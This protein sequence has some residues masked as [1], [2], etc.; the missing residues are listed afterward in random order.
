MNINIS[1]L[2]IVEPDRGLASAPTTRCCNTTYEATVRWSEGLQ[3]A[4]Q[5]DVSIPEVALSALLEGTR[6][7]TC[8]QVCSLMMPMFSRLVANMANGIY[9]LSACLSIVG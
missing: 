8:R 3:S 9:F 2:V 4:L 1:T 5:S 6:H 7:F